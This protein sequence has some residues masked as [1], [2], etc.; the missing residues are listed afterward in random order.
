MKVVGVSRTRIGRLLV[1]VAA[2]AAAVLAL[3]TPAF[4]HHPDISASVT[5]TGRVSFTSTAWEG[6]DDDPNTTVDE[7][8]RS[9]TNPDIAIAYS[10]TGAG[11]AFTTVTHR[12]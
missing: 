7:N 11:G 6:V 5:C 12:P 4:A 9:R 8:E 3:A 2:T 1:V 10:V